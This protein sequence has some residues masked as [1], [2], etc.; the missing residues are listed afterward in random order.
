MSMTTPLNLFDQM[1]I[2]FQEVEYTPP[3]ANPSGWIWRCDSQG[4]YITC[5]GETQ[6]ILGLAGEAFAGNSLDD[7]ALAPGSAA[8]LKA[9]LE[10]GCFPIEMRLEYL[11]ATGAAIP[12]CMHINPTYSETGERNGWHGFVLK[13]YSEASQP[14]NPKIESAQ[15]ELRHVASSVILDILDNLRK[16]SPA[17]KKFPKSSVTVNELREAAP[18]G[19]SAL[20]QFYFGENPASAGEV[21][22]I[23]HKLKWG[24]KFDFD[25]EEDLF[26]RRSKFSGRGLRGYMERLSAPNKIIKC[27]LRWIAVILRIDADGAQ[28]WVDYPQ[29]EAAPRK[30]ALDEFLDQPDSL[31]PE[32]H[33]ALNNPRESLITYRIGEDYLIDPDAD[34]SHGK[35]NS[36][37]RQNVSP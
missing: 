9:A 35:K 2:D 32:I 1:V 36:R 25:Y 23:E 26:I 16:V 20:S 6:D 31:T 21:I 37:Q 24:Y 3:D 5:S 19:I 11:H 33:G 4:R 22:V 8:H 14:S 34:L 12:V 13:L 17:I 15:G 30:V 18:D 27:D 7:F 10:E 28:V 29:G